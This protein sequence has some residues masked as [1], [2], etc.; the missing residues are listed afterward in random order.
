MKVQTEQVWSCDRTTSR[1]GRVRS[2]RPGDVTAVAVPESPL[3][4]RAL[5]SIDWSD[6]YAVSL[7]DRPAGYPQE[8]ADAIFRSPPIWV[9]VLFRLREVLVRAVGIESGG[10]HV[11]DTVSWCPDEVLLGIDQGH[12]S[13]RASVLLEPNRVVLTTVVKVH[14]RRGRVYSPL[15][16]LVHPVV[17]RTMLA[18]ATR[19]MRGET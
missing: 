5:P 13:F 17:V 19:T 9:A 16:R 8:W 14:N 10:S 11:F 7:T 2:A 12:L 15:V 1:A 3:L 18:R 6:A 4:A